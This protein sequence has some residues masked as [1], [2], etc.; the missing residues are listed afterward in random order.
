MTGLGLSVQDLL[1]IAKN[2]LP[3]LPPARPGR[4]P[5]PTQDSLAV[6]V[7]GSCRVSQAPAAAVVNIMI[8]TVGVTACAETSLSY[9][10]VAQSTVTVTR[11]QAS[12]CT[13]SPRR[14]P[15]WRLLS[16]SLAARRPSQP[17]D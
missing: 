4:A 12:L 8:M 3:V 14:R 10:D 16:G 13:E 17:G 11:T 5:G 9:S 1:A 6:Q 7:P 2:H 15:E